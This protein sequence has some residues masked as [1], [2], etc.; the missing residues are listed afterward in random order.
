VTNKSHI[1]D[2]KRSVH[3]NSNLENHL[4]EARKNLNSAQGKAFRK[5][6]SSEIETHFGQLKGNRRFRRLT[7]STIEKVEVEVGLHFTAQNIKKMYQTLWLNGIGLLEWREYKMY[8]TK[9]WRK[10]EKTSSKASF[11]DYSISAWLG[12]CVNLLKKVAHL[13]P[14][15]RLSF[16]DGGFVVAF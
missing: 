11:F 8:L 7:H 15:Q 13:H 4:N 16:F 12:S 6:R 10:A 9:K 2:R 5:K 3:R 1:L 14:A